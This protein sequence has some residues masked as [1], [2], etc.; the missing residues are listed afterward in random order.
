MLVV[1]QKAK[2]I[3]ISNEYAIFDQH[4]QQIGAVREVGQST[5]KKAARLLT[6]LDQYMTHKL[7]IVD[8]QG[9]PLLTLTRPA[10][11]IKSRIIVK[12]PAGGEIG[13]IVQ[14]NMF[15]RIRFGLEAGGQQIGSING[16]NWR[17]WNSNIKDHTDAEVA[18]I[19]K[20]WEGLAKTMF[21]TADNYV[22]QIHRPLE[23]P[24]R[25]LVVAAACSVDTALKQDPAASVDRP[26]HRTLPVPG[27]SPSALACG[28][29]G[30][31][32][33]GVQVGR[34]A[35]HVHLVDEVGTAGEHGPGP[36]VRTGL[37]ERR[38][39][40]GRR[41]DG[42]GARAGR[43]SGRPRYVP[44]ATRRARR[45]RPRRRPRARPRAG[46]PVRRYR[47]PR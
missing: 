7:Q 36:L 12:D 35:G 43:G 44:A 22:V 24:L 14:Q 4:A 5:L 8:M 17:A 42:R 30:E 15:G 23:P 13:Q 2:F 33:G 32:L 25:S 45:A 31:V 41:R 1:N 40:L 39:P 10:K 34:V 26:C 3:E 18:R 19:T 46:P 27:R 21:T 16:E 47:R 6:S 9:T 11:L 29:A 38:T 28:P 37:G 20:T